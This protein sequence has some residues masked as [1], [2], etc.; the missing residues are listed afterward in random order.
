MG[1]GRIVGSVVGEVG[2]R[3]PSDR[4]RRWESPLPG[5]GEAS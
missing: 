4:S 2:V 5:S 3:D 1:E